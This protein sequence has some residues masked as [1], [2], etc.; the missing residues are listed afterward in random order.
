MYLQFLHFDT[1]YAVSIPITFSPTVMTS[2]HALRM[3]WIIHIQQERWAL[4]CTLLGGS[5][6]PSHLLEHLRDAGIKLLY[7]RVSTLILLCSITIAWSSKKICCPMLFSKPCLDSTGQQVNH[8]F[9]TG[10]MYITKKNHAFIKRKIKG[11]KGHLYFIYTNSNRKSSS[12]NSKK[13]T[14]QPFSLGISWILLL[15][16]WQAE[17]AG[18]YAENRSSTSA[19]EQQIFMQ[20]LSVYAGLS[21]KPLLG[22][23]GWLFFVLYWR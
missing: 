17:I 13:H 3:I 16:M 14:N 6:V 2:G 1:T 10:T 11:R 19:I 5:F 12:E 23:Q 9:C 22:V 18:K 8:N 4:H 7:L 20:N 15:S 21:F